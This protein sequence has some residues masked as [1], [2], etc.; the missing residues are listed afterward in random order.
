VPIK[1]ATVSEAV[2]KASE[3]LKEKIIQLLMLS[4]HIGKKLNN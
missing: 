3:K 1:T 4:P 2:K